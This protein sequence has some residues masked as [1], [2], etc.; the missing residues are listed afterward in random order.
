MGKNETPCTASPQAENGHIDIAHELAEAFYKLQLSGYQWRLLWVIFRQTYGWKK[1]QDRISI[2][3]FEE[4]T[5]IDRRNIAHA[6]SDLAERKIIVKNN[7]GFIVSYGI[8]KNYVKWICKPLLK[9]TT[10]RNKTEL[11]QEDTSKP[12]LKSPMLKSTTKPLLKSTPTKETKETI[13]RGIF[14]QISEL[15]KRYSDQ[16]T[17]NQAFQ[18]IASTRKSNRIADSVKLS[19]LKAWERYAVNQVIAGIHTYLEKDHAEREHIGEG[20][21]ESYLL[22]IIRKSGNGQQMEGESAGVQVMK[23]TGSALLDSHYKSQGIR[24]I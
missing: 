17:I 24:I 5:G 14:S 15:E 20:K 13:L 22:G 1:K 12:L 21:G 16:E 18:D 3:F 11:S 6:L 2:S 8:Q 7:N 19:I 4:R 9:S 23:S 10:R